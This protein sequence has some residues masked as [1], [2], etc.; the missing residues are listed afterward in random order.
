MELFLVAFRVD[1]T[2]IWTGEC[3]FGW[4]AYF[5]SINYCLIR[6]KILFEEQQY[7]FSK[8]IKISLGIKY[9]H[10]AL[11]IFQTAL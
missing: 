7:L 6:R 4:L 10:L 2:Q 1:P 3:C 8:M 9:L 5:E 11:E